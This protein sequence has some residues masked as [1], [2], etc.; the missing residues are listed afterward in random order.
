MRLF[1]RGW[2]ARPRAARGDPVEEQ[3]EEVSTDR[4][5]LLLAR[6][7]RAEVLAAVQRD[8]DDYIE[9]A[10]QSVDLLRRMLRTP[11]PSTPR[12]RA[13]RAQEEEFVRQHTRFA[14]VVARIHARLVTS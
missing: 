5:L 13:T 10:A 1:T 4:V 2:F 7:T 8:L 3:E 9:G 14:A 12:E 6:E 11:V